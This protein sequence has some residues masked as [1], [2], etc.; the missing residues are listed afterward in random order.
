MATNPLL[1][2]QKKFNLFKI[3]DKRQG[4][5]FSVI[6]GAVQVKLQGGAIGLIKAETNDFYSRQGINLKIGNVIEAEITDIIDGVYFLTLPTQYIFS[7]SYQKAEVKFSGTQAVVVEFPWQEMVNIGLYNPD[8]GVEPGFQ[9]LDEGTRVICRGLRLIEDYYQIR[10][11]ALDNEPEFVPEIEEIQAKDV[12]EF[13][14]V[15]EPTDFKIPAP[16][17]DEKIKEVAKQQEGL[18]QKGVYKLGEVYLCKCTA[19]G[20][21]VKFSDGNQA[22]IKK[23]NGFAPVKGEDLLVRL[24]RIYSFG[25]YKDVE[26]LDVVDKDYVKYFKKIRSKNLLPEQADPRHKNRTVSY[27][28]GYR[29]GERDNEIYKEGMNN[30]SEDHFEKYWLGFLYKIP[31]KSS[32]PVFYDNNGANI[33]VKLIENDDV[34]FVNGQIAFCRLHYIENNKGK[35]TFTVKVEFSREPKAEEKF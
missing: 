14:D 12:E 22:T 31:V 7:N 23:K 2:L 20:N 9:A 27:D 8:N 5:V 32:K 19:N 6:D 3:G 10:E 11:L 29:F 21:L 34:V 26:I 16:W 25:N 35:V 13:E 17:S 15:S 4:N 33:T 18:V 24:I 30:K 28:C 1:E